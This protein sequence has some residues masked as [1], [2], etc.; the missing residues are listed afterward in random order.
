MRGF[1]VVACAA[2]TMLMSEGLVAAMT[3]V[4]GSCSGVSDGPLRWS[5]PVVKSELRF[6][7]DLWRR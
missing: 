3:L 1:R 6:R 7:L 4:V 5:S 2:T